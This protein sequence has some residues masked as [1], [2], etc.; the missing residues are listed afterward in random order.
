MKTNLIYILLFKKIIPTVLMLGLFSNINVLG[1]TFNI[2]N[3]IGNNR[4]ILIDPGHGGIDGGA[5]SKRGT[6]EKHINLKISLKLRDRL[7]NLGFQVFLTRENDSGLYTEKGELSELKQ[8]DLNNRCEMKKSLSSIF[9]ISIHQNFFHMSS[10]N[11][12]QVW[13]SENHESW[14]MAHIIQNNLNQDLGY[15][16]RNEMEAKELYKVL[17]CYKEIP[18]ILIECGFLTNPEDE[19]KLIT[20][21]YQDKI[22][23][24][25]TKSIEEYFNHL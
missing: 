15:Y 2:P 1:N 5:V 6:I 16:L 21:F 25:I 14:R 24:S 18:S 23:S 13:Y 4:I 8:E 7:C 19:K 17:R 9:F 3:K 12:P 10:C 20:N 22:A 11:G